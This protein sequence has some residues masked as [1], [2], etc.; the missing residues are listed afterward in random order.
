MQIFASDYNPELAARALDDKRVNKMVLES[1]QLLSAA[2]FLAMPS[3]EQKHEMLSV[4]VRKGIS[5]NILDKHGNPVNH[6]YLPCGP[7]WC[8]HPLAKWTGQSRKNFQWLIDHLEALIREHFVRTGNTHKYV[9][10]PDFYSKFVEL[11]KYGRELTPFL[12][13]TAPHFKEPIYVSNTDIT[14]IYKDYLTEKW[15]LDKR[16]PKWT[17]RSKPNW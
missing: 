17:N 10:H 5:T 11:L 7:G 13:C 14:D 9:D 16:E 15:R 8:N 4:K 1:S 3:V 12:N 2:L 6:P